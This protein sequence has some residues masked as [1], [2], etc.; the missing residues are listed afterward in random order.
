MCIWR[1][2]RGEVSVSFSSRT[3]STFPSCKS[4]SQ[5]EESGWW[6]DAE[7]VGCVRWVDRV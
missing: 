5:T 7:T 6:R 4:I 3:L 2:V 1:A